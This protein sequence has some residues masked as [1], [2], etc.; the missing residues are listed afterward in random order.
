MNDLIENFC[1]CATKI[2]GKYLLGLFMYQINIPWFIYGRLNIFI[3][4]E[5]NAP[6]GK[7]KI[8]VLILNLNL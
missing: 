7:M 8:G 2:I 6:I 1:A 3:Y 4:L 5:Q